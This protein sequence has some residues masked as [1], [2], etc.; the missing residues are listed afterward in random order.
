MAST[1]QGASIPAAFPAPRPLP[2]FMTSLPLTLQ[3]YWRTLFWTT[4]AVAICGAAYLAEKYIFR[5]ALG[6]ISSTDYRMFKNPAELPMRLFGLPHFVV[7][8]AFLLSSKRMRG[9]RSFATLGGLAAIALA[10]CYGFYRIGAHTSPLA[11][12]LFYAYFMVHGFRDEAFFYKAFGD[13]PKDETRVQERVVGVLQLLLLGIILA[14]IIPAYILYAQY[15]PRFKDPALEAL[16]PAQWPYLVRIA[17]LLL[18]MLGIAT[19]ALWRIARIYPDGLH[20][21]WRMHRSILIVFLTGTGII[22]LSLFS[23]PW[24]FN[25]VVLMHF[26]GWYLFGRYSLAKRPPPVT[27]PVG[28]WSWMR[29]TRTGFTWFHLGLAA[30]VIALVAV[31]TYGFG[32]TGVLEQV[33]GSKSFY[34]W[35]IFH[36][37]L[38]FFPR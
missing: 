28:S 32:K 17:A 3:Q 5:D 10:L 9:A 23:G 4:L 36:V 19:F 21:L 33:V 16:F 13:M 27:P 29:T 12:L 18:P 14:L 2:G 8:T 7:G 34:Y 15:Y 11:L 35:T 1:P 26:V 20:G 24:S 37:T 30:L 25:V 31:S 22:L 38:S 6:V